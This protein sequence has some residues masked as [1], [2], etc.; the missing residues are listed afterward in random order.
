MN[1]LNKEDLRIEIDSTIEDL[2]YEAEGEREISGADCTIYLGEE[3]IAGFS[4]RPCGF[5]KVYPYEGYEGYKEE[6]E[7]YLENIDNQEMEELVEHMDEYNLALEEK[8][9]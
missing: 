5:C 9:C 6:L 3:M 8:V 2:K 4:L 7:E 1:K